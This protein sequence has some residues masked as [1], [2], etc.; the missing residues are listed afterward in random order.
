MKKL[1]ILVDDGQTYS[2]IF[3]EDDRFLGDVQTMPKDMLKRMLEAR[4]KQMHKMPETDELYTD[5]WKFMRPAT[6]TPPMVKK[7]VIVLIQSLLNKDNWAFV[8][9]AG[10]QTITKQTGIEKLFGGFGGHK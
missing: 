5:R 1:Y 3:W 4:S 7:D 6:N 9:T 2:T 10:L 8:G